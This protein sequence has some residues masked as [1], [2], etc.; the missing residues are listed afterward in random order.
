MYLDTLYCLVCSSVQIDVN[1]A[2]VSIRNFADP[3]SSCAVI[4]IG[5]LTLL[6]WGATISSGT[7]R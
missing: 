1:Q 2:V 4:T 7:P 3:H 5:A 6:E